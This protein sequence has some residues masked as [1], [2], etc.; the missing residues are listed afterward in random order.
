MQSDRRFNGKEMWSNGQIY[1]QLGQ[2]DIRLGI[3]R[4]KQNDTGRQPASK[5]DRQGDTE[6]ETTNI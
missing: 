1:G 4:D 3:Q 5:Y 2:T 6:I